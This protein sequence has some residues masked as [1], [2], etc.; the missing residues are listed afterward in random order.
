VLEG[1][2]EFERVTGGTPGSREARK[3]GEEYLLK[4]SLFRRLST[5]EPAGEQFL[6]T[7]YGRPDFWE[8]SPEGWPQRWDSK[9]G[10]FRLDGR[11]TA[12]WSRIRAGR[13]EDLGTARR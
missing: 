5:G 1:L 6:S 11:P 8:D 12:Q 4:R 9:G 7:V 10:Q 13:D 3:S 2:L